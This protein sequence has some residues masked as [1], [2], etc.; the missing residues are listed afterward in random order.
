M[1]EHEGQSGRVQSVERAMEIVETAME[2]EGA[3]VSELAAELD[4]AKS[5]IHG[6]LATLH[7]LGY[8]V[9]EEEGYQIGTRFLRFGEYSRTREPEYRM[10][11]KKVTELAEETEERS[12]FVIEE[13]G[14]GVF[15]YRE[16]G[17]HAVETGSGTGKRMYLH[18]TSAGKAIL[19]HL[20]DETIDQI[21]DRWGLPAVT[22]ATITDEGTLRDELA[23]I[24][25][26]GF[27]LNREENIEGLHAVGVPV[28]RQD[29]TVIGAL[30]ISSPTH[31]LKGKYL[32]NDLSDLL[33]GTANELELN[34]AYS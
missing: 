18:A 22:P 19:A 29:G 9:K 33:L 6:Y 10:A 5:T 21:L 30:S 15:L 7:H 1:E 25:E 23:E 20:P 2:M 27:A 32:L 16:S 14:R 28:Q 13:L 11:A 3:G 4:I 24:R 31:R 17:A 34:I 12:Q 8:L 26:R